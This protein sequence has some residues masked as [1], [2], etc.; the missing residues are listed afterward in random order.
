M[1]Q[2]PSYPSQK[3]P[4]ILTTPTVF[5][6]FSYL[7]WGMR[8]RTC[9]FLCLHACSQ[10]PLDVWYVV[11]KAF[12]KGTQRNW[13]RGKRFSYGRV[14]QRSS[15]MN[16]THRGEWDLGTRIDLSGGPGSDVRLLSTLPGTLEKGGPSIK[17]EFSTTVQ[18]NTGHDKAQSHFVCLSPSTIPILVKLGTYGKLRWRK[19]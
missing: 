6:L 5:S 18:G 17:L 4:F 1:F 9:H 12:S 19:I 14:I 13:N 11:R 15:L 10:N 8:N 2:I 7:L 3:I 16:R